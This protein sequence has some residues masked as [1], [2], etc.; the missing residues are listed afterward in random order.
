MYLV[1]CRLA[2][3]LQTLLHACKITVDDWHLCSDMTSKYLKLLTG[4]GDVLG[5]GDQQ[6]GQ[7]MVTTVATA[8]AWL[9]AS[10]LTGQDR[11]Q[12][13]S[14]RGRVHSA[15]VQSATQCQEEYCRF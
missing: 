7:A 14:I 4:R 12:L 11:P 10:V 6:S 13:T 2:P 1:I 9:V 3:E 8:A 5:G 15:A